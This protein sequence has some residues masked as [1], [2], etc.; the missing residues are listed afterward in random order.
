MKNLHLTARYAIFIPY[1][2]P[3][4]YTTHR[5]DA[6]LTAKVNRLI[7][8]SMN[9]TLLYDKNTSHSLQATEGIS[10]GVAYTFP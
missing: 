7:N 9:A 5:L 8:V 10:M 1:I 3:L 6:T 4:A 2:Q